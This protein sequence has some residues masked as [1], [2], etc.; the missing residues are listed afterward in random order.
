MGEQQGVLCQPTAE[1]DEDVEAEREAASQPD[2]QATFV[3][4]SQRLKVQISTCDAPRTKPP[5]AR[6]GI[7]MIERPDR[8]T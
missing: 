2:N 8:P 1:D 6:I 7:M 3:Q 4:N 5:P